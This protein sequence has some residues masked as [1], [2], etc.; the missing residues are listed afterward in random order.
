MAVMKGSIMGE[1]D[2]INNTPCA[3]DRHKNTFV[4]KVEYSQRGTWQ[5][6]VIWAEENR[7]VRF[8]SALELIRL[9][10]EV[11]RKEEVRADVQ[12]S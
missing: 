1:S 9:M 3:A 12:V 5:G 8:R 6:K 4:V 7:A 2:S 10:D 11:I